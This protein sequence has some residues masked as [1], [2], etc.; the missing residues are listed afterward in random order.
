MALAQFAASWVTEGIFHFKVDKSFTQMYRLLRL[1]VD[2]H[3][4][5]ECDL[6]LCSGIDS[7]LRLCV[8][9]SN[10]QLFRIGRSA[11][12]MI[13][14]SEWRLP[15]Q[16]RLSNIGWIHRQG[17][18]PL[19]KGMV[20]F[21]PHFRANPYYGVDWQYVDGIVSGEENWTL[22]CDNWAPNQYCASTFRE[23]MN[24]A[25]DGHTGLF[26]DTGI[27]VKLRD[28]DVGWVITSYNELSV[29]RESMIVIQYFNFKYYTRAPGIMENFRRRYRLGFGTEHSVE[30]MGEKTIVVRS[31]KAEDDLWY[32]IPDELWDKDRHIGTDAEFSN[33]LMLGQR[34]VGVYDK[35]VPM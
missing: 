5:G 7:Q 1:E 26:L 18:T 2:R 34:Q 14:M 29:G 15:V 12:R 8:H 27:G 6:S 16:L 22:Q 10:Y 28:F 19:V 13:P 11:H 35:L 30:K 32:Q 20:S 9:P 4:K 33:I 25:P 17:G 3:Y 24:Y 21:N 23:L 31:Y